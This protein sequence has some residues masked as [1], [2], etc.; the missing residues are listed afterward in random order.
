MNMAETNT[1]LNH[2]GLILDGNRRWAKERN[3]SMLEGHRKGYEVFKEVALEAFDK[4]IYC[5][6]AYIF[7]SENWKRTEEEVS[8]LMKLVL[9]AMKQYIKQFGV[10]GIKIRVIGSRERLSRKLIQ[11]IESAES[12]TVNNTKG[13]LALCFNYGGK[14]EIIDAIK[15]LPNEEKAELT[16]KKFEQYLYAKDLPPLDM[17][18]RT[19]GEKRLSG[20][21]LWWSA[22]SEILFIDKYWPDFTSQDLNLIIDDY[23]QRQRKFGV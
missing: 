3:L 11:A 8:Y 21:M 9:R 23:R 19:S 7:S 20:F 4:G 18:V 5:V 13:I 17:I 16:P 22:Y 1:T 15:A 12:Q 10:K 6:S 2:L 14:Q